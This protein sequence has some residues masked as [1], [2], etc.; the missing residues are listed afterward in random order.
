MVVSARVQARITG[1]Y[2]IS[3][4]IILV[5]LLIAS[6]IASFVALNASEGSYWVFAQWWYLDIPWFLLTLSA[7]IPTIQLAYYRKTFVTVDWKEP[8][9][10]C[11]IE[12]TMFAGK[13]IIKNKY[14]QHMSV[15]Q[16]ASI[17]LLVLISL[18]LVLDTGML[19]YAWH[20][21]VLPGNIINKVNA[22]QSSCMPVILSSV[23][24]RTWTYWR[25]PNSIFLL[26]DGEWLSLQFADSTP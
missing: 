25:Y 13:W 22:I 19:Y 3:Y 20:P 8:E 12:G 23:L 4:V 10:S 16:A 6:V 9:R 5:S 24:V 1:K 2:R 11:Y 17:I 21:P 14:P 26:R 18:M 7:W 15:A